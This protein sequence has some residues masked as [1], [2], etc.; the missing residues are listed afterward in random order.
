MKQIVK[1]NDKITEGFQTAVL[2]L[3]TGKVVSGVVR[4][5]DDKRVVLVDA[6][7]TQTIVDAAEIDDRFE[8]LSA[9]P[10]ELMKLM[11]PRDLRDLV[12]FLSQQRVTADGIQTAAPSQKEGHAAGQ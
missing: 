8:G 4:S 6:D 1:P 10:E 2:Q 3:A 5:E 12:E 11:T 7:G 9:M